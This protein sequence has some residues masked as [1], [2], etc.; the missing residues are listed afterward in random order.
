M[1]DSRGRGNA[2]TAPGETRGSEPGKARPARLG[3]GPRN[4][5][6]PPAAGVA[7]RTRAAALDRP[8]GGPTGCPRDGGRLGPRPSEAQAGV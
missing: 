3:P 8:L 2:G 4:E 5:A 6:T 7:A 1:Q